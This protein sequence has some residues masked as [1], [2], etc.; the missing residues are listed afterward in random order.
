MYAAYYISVRVSASGHASL[1]GNPQLREDLDMQD[2]TCPT[3]VPT[4]GNI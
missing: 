4:G 2:M 1:Q 3:F